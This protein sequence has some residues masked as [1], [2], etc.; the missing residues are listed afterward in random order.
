MFRA[1]IGVS[2][3]SEQGCS[4]GAN[5]LSSPAIFEADRE[6]KAMKGLLDWE[7]TAL[8]LGSIVPLKKKTS[9]GYMGILL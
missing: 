5:S 9:M 6:S 2:T 7:C 3:E 8:S 1:E 4:Q